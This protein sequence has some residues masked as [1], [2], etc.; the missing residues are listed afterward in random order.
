[1]TFSKSACEKFPS[2]ITEKII[3]TELLSIFSNGVFQRVLL[4]VFKT[5]SSSTSDF[6]ANVKL[7][8]KIQLGIPGKL[9]NR[10]IG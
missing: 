10:F 2:R 4:Y 1:M 6:S 8:D 5:S 7:E 3:I 9:F